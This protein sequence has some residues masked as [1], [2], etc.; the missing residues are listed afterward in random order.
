MVIRTALRREEPRA[1]VAAIIVNIQSSFYTANRM[2]ERHPAIDIKAQRMRTEA[3]MYYF[4]N[5]TA[6]KAECIAR[7]IT[8]KQMFGCGERHLR[9]LRQLWRCW[10]EYEYLREAYAGQGYG[11]KLAFRL[12]GI[13]VDSGDGPNGH[14]GAGH[15]DKDTK[16]EWRT[17]WW[18]FYPIH[19]AIGF[20]VD[21]AATKYTTLLARW[22]EDS[23]PQPWDGETGWL[24]AP[25]TRGLL[26]QFVAKCVTGGARIV[27]ALLPAAMN[28][29][30]FQELVMPHAVLLFP[31]KRLAFCTGSDNEMDGS[32]SPFNVTLAVF[33]QTD[34]VLAKLDGYI[35]NKTLCAS[36]SI[37]RPEIVALRRPA[38]QLVTA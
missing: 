23:L 19:A 24:N 35:S 13:P 27:V 29:G 8:L 18:F 17:P 7:G 3:A 32:T 25:F 15:A 26:P 36:L 20:T 38:L 1:D 14:Q 16:G 31:D 22:F 34:E 12:V 10:T 33:G 30:W 9:K 6:I 21:L 5:A 37:P 2:E 28:V 4:E 11:I